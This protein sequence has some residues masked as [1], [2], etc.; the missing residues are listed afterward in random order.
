MWF[1]G[2]EQCRTCIGMEARLSV[3][4]TLSKWFL[5]MFG[6]TYCAGNLDEPD[7]ILLTVPN[8]KNNQKVLKIVL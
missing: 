4:M 7:M 6:V 5:E 1:A 8:I 3:K 2:F